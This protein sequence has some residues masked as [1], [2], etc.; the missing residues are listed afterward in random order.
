MRAVV[1]HQSCDWNDLAIEQVATPPLV[2]G[3]VRIAIAYA[4]ISFAMSLQVAGK[5]QRSYPMP[6]TPGTEVAGTVLEVAPG[7]TQVRPGDRVLAITDWGGLAEQV[8]V[9]ASTVYRLPDDSAGTMLFLPALHLPNAYG[10]AYGALFWRAALG[11]GETVLVTGAGGAVGSAAIELARH[12]GAR[13]IA[14]ASTAEKRDFALARGADVAIGYE[15]LRDDA[16]AASDGA[17][18]DVVI[19]QVGGDA[20]DNA[21]RT[22]RPFGRM[23][24]VGFAGG[25]IP[26][27]PANLLLV[28]NIAVVGHNMGLYYGWGPVDLRERY[29][30]QMRSMVADLFTWTRAGHLRPQ[31]SHVLPFD[32]FR[33]A[34]RLIRAR[35]AQGKVVVRIGHDT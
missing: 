12:R 1:C 2:A 20:F 6:F 25:R 21:L 23:V 15:R 16:L 27:T 22:L 19:D 9:R 5:Y 3:G 26:Q 7:V 17:G 13:V 4:S 14:A 33:E 34:M 11:A 31:V 32:D 28:K 29:E 8:V 24:A 35:E 18:V 30:S 10:T